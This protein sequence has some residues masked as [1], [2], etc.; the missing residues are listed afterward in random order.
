MVNKDLRNLVKADE[1]KPALVNAA[2]LL[3]G[4]RAVG[5]LYAGGAVAIAQ[6]GADGETADHNR[7]AVSTPHASAS[8]DNP[9]RWI[10]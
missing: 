7:R 8:A 1:E 9:E 5:E 4:N 10:G 3:W 6:H 2:R